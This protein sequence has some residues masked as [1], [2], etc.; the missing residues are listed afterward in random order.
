ME[1]NE[2]R[3][4]VRS[5]IGRLIRDDSVYRLPDGILSEDEFLSL[6]RIIGGGVTPANFQGGYG[7]AVALIPIDRTAFEKVGP[8]E[9]DIRLCL[10]F[11]T[12]MS[13]AWAGRR[14]DNDTIPLLLGQSVG[15]DDT[16]AVPS[17][18]FISRSG[19]IYFGTAAETQHRQEVDPKRVRFDNLKW[20][21][22]E[23]EVGQ[24]LDDVPLPNGVDPTESG[25]T[26]GDL[27]VL[28]LA[29][30][31]DHALKSLEKALIGPESTDEKEAGI[32][33]DELRYVRRRYAIPCFENAEDETDDG[34]KRGRWA[35][36]VMERA[37]LR[38]QVVADSLTNMW[39]DL[40]VE[41]VHLLLT[42]CRKTVDTSQLIKLLTRNAPVREPVAA[43][44]S[45]FNEEIEETTITRH[46]GRVIR[47]ALLV[48]DAGAGTTDF[49]LFQVA[50]NHELGTIRYA[51]IS[52]SVRMCRVAGNAVDEILQ[53][54]VLI[55]CGIDP[56]TGAPRS[57]EDFR[58]IKISLSSRIRD[59]KKDLFNTGQANIQLRP[60][61]TGVL[62]RDR[63]LENERYI[64]LD[65]EIR[66]VRGRVVRA[67]FG[68]ETVFS[69][70]RERFFGHPYPIHVLLTGGSSEVPFVRSLAEGRMEFNG[71]A[72]EFHPIERR[73]SWIDTL[74]REDAEL[75]YNE[76]PQC[77]VAIGG[78]AAELPEE[79]ADLGRLVTPAPPGPRRL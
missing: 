6:Q 4:I 11:G 49:A 54:I 27:L 25:L 52:P 41:P 17:T 26:K 50:D 45:R 69:A 43:G 21:L 38:A 57:E 75:L 40:R 30:L 1:I 24:E 56:S 23:A 59:I 61:V 28:Y 46:A 70:I 18:I 55:E 16:L 73:P 10:D 14:A 35:R 67:A 29:W 37:L 32:L 48:V 8:R 20:M 3:A 7:T 34:A 31:T 47:R 22:S 65:K 66:D 36:T 51:L 71:V 53:Q 13:K 12:A 44:A 64:E 78:A 68:D 2:A 62:T 39:N 76:Y 79:I 42:E 19:N 15:V 63:V 72:F 74:P 33:S 5:F 77:A 58:H 9:N 60:N